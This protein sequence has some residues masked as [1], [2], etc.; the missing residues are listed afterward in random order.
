MSVRVFFNIYVELIIKFL[1]L[2]EIKIF[3]LL[4]GKLIVEINMVNFIVI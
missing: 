2:F 3:R 4:K 1:L